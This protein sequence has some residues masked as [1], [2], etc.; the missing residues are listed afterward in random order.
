MEL[1]RI[2]EIERRWQRRWEEEGIFEADADKS[3]K[4]YFLTVPYPYTSGVLHVG[5][6]R[7]YTLGDIT[8]RYFR[9]RGRNVLWP[10]AWHITG[11]PI[12][13]I[14][15]R[16]ENGEESIIKDHISYVSL[17]DPERAEEIVKGFT[18]P[19]KVATY[20]ASVISNDLKELGCSIDWRRQFTTGEPIYNQFIRWQYHH[21]NSLGYLKK[22]EHPVFFCPSCN[23]PVTTDDVKSG[24]ELEMSIAEFV[25]IKEKLGDAYLVAATLRPETIFGVTNVWVNP[26]ATYVEAN[27]DDERWI[28]SKPCAEKL[29]NQRFK[30]EV[31]REFKGSELVGKKALIPLIDKEVLIL[32]ASFVDAD[33]ATGV[34]N[35]VP[36]H[37]PFDFIMLE[38]L[39]KD[40][41]TLEKFNLPAREIESITPI[42]LITLKGFAE[43]PAKEI[44][45]KLG[46]ASIEERKK[47][48]KATQELY[49]KEFY[50]GT[51]NERC[52]EFAGKKVRDA[53]IEVTKKLREMNAAERM[54]ENATKDKQ[55]NEVRDIF[56]RC[57]A[58]VVVKLL[59]DQWFLNYADAGW[60]ERAREMLASMRIIPETYRKQ[61]LHTIDWLH[62]WACARTRGLG[63]RLPYDERW[64]IESLSDSTIYMA[65]Y[66]IVHLIRKYDLK[67]EQLTVDFF[68]YVFLGK[69]DK[70]KINVEESML[71][72]MREE[73]LYWYPLDERR[74]GIAHVSN[75]LTFFIF[76]HAAIFPRE[77]WP[78]SISLNEMLIAEGKKMSKSLGN[79]IPLVKAIRKYCAD[80][81]RLYL[82]GNVEAETTLDWREKEIS[83]YARKLQRFFELCEEIISSDS[84]EEEKLVERWFVSKFYLNLKEATLALERRDFKR[85]VQRMFFETINDVEHLISRSGCTRAAKRVLREWLISLSPVIPHACEE[86]WHRLG[87]EG[88]VS[89]ESWPEVSD[90]LI[91]KELLNLENEFRKTLEDVSEVIK[92]IGKKERLYLYFVSEKEIEYFKES[93]EYIKK[94]FGFSSVEFYKFND[95]KRYDPQNRAAHAKYGKPAIYLE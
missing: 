73:F 72:R 42:T 93:A 62:E 41:E 3:R 23:N 61:F 68:D 83:N 32:P 30:V 89:L 65:F 52:M 34:V 63:T 86:F 31:I 53:K 81:V 58:R 28:I 22:G 45:E 39:K 19:N 55:G 20:Y 95:E 9:L 12:L 77:L 66:T 4:K 29:A 70:S 16:I 47:L 46:I 35:S 8:A 56:C 91:D 75:H 5:H 18:D 26:D 25:L 10:I 17:H 40:R 2:R 57:G 11:T 76:H 79:V 69:G 44:C 85:Y 71:E 87:N 38:E 15:K 60:K 49:G 82:A 88:F 50:L 90:E 43:C 92:V 67:P 74:T 24:D 51:L 37:A 27:V 48:E 13:A 14:S 33:V 64:I 78:K 6:G 21:L 84:A 59:K 94:R 7:T 80:A 36:A 54:F 1:E